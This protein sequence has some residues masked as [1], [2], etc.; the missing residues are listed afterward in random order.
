[1]IPKC[2]LLFVFKV[3][4]SESKLKLSLIECDREKEELE[5]KGTVLEREKAEQSQTIR[6][7]CDTDCL[8][9]ILVY[10]VFLVFVS[11]KRNKLDI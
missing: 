1:M 11:R 8:I 6:Y 10:I 5:M 2:V 4:E 7:T 3:M 9:S